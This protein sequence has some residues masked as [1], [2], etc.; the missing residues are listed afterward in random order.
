[1]VKYCPGLLD[2]H[3]WKPVNKLAHRSAV[4]KVFKQ[5]R[6]RHPCATKYPCTADNTW[7]LFDSGAGRPVNHGG[8]VALAHAKEEI[9]LE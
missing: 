8:I 7:M 2:G 1:M 9:V 6:Y 3:T 4:F 5:R